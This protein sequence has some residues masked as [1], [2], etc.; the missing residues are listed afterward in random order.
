MPTRM[1]VC[2]EC[3]GAGGWYVHPLITP[4]EPDERILPK[5]SRTAIRPAPL[6]VCWRCEGT[7]LVVV[8][9]EESSE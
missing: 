9:T 8:E 1:E 3:H 7:G 6:E 5:Q 4:D 2:P